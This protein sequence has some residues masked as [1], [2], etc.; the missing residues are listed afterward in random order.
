MPQSNAHVSALSLACLASNILL[1][2]LAE[3]GLSKQLVSVIMGLN[4][5]SIIIQPIIATQLALL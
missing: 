4:N 1:V 2:I 5:I 3:F